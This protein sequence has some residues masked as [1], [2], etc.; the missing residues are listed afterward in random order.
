MQ[1]KHVR[2]QGKHAAN[3][4]PRHASHKQ[5][6]NIKIEP[7]TL[8]CFLVPLIFVILLTAVLFNSGEKTSKPEISAV[9]VSNS[10]TDTSA[11]IQDTEG[12]SQSEETVD[13]TGYN[14]TVKAFADAN[15][16]DY[17]EYPESLIALLERNSETEDFVLSYPLEKDKAVSVDLSG[18][19]ISE[20]VP[21]F[22]QWDKQW[23]YISYAGNF[24]GLTACGPV[25]LSMC[26]YYLTGDSDM[27]PDK[28]MAYAE[29]N[30]YSQSGGGTS[31]DLFNIGAVNLGFDIT[32]I[33]LVKSRILDNLEAGNPII[34]HM[35]PGDF[36]SSGHYVVFAGCEGEYIKIN[37]PNSKANS[38]KLW[39]YEEIESQIKNIWVIR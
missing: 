7:R 37:D 19:D 2:Y 39:T 31:W 16:I 24:A 22:M 20:G 23:G 17:S 21:L 4:A 27:S 32:E 33:P 13:Y 11:V 35:G 9:N 5:K 26:A 28:M 1:A 15:G 38:E 18:Y 36:T 14:A 25:C 8:F 30:G 10:V 6:R 34:C 3:T 12:A 29:N